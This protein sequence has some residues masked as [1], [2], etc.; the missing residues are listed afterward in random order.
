MNTPNEQVLKKLSGLKCQSGDGRP[1]HFV[2][3]VEKHGTLG[4]AKGIYIGKR[5]G[6]LRVRRDALLTLAG[7]DKLS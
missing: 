2:L 6:L 4:A 1:L 3:N 5:L 7:F